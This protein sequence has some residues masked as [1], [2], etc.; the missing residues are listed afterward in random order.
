MRAIFGPVQHQRQGNARL[1]YDM[2]GPV[3]GNCSGDFL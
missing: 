1:P 3:R 2:F